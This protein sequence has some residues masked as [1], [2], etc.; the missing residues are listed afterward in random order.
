MPA[1]HIVVGVYH[2]RPKRL[3]FHNDY[4]L[5]CEGARRA[6]QIRTFEVGHLFWIPLLPLGFWKRW[7]CTVCGHQPHVNRK[8]RRSFKWAGLFALLI[9]SLLFWAEPP[10]ADFVTGGWI[11]RIAAPL[12]A[13]LLLAHLLRTPRDPSLKEKLAA[14][15]PA[16]DTACPFCGAQLLILGSQC[17]CP[18]CGVVRY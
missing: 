18:V 12:G 11:L 1:I 7:H 10:P 17:S 6:A 5:S 2:F 3:A 13:V 16:A 9:A 4:C 8:T 15:L 14:I